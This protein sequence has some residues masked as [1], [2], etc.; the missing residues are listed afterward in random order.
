MTPGPVWRSREIRPPARRFYGEFLVNAQGEDVVAG[1]R[2]PFDIEEMANRLPVA[3]EELLE[4]QERLER[5]FRDM[6]DL[7]FTVER[8][9]LYLLQ[10]S[11]GKRTAA[12]AVR[13]AAEM[14]EEG[15][16]PEKRQSAASQP[17]SS[18]SSCTRS[19]I[20]RPARSRFAGTAGKPRG[21]ERPGGVRPRRGRAAQCERRGGD[22]RSRRDHAGRLPR[23]RCSTCGAHRTR[24]YDE[25][26]RGRG[27]RHGQVCDRRL[28]GDH[29]DPEKHTFS[30]DGT[31]VSEGDWITLDGA[32]GRV[33]I[34]DLP[35]IP[36]EIVRVMSGALPASRAP[37][38][39]RSRRPRL[40][41]R[42]ASSSRASERRHS[43]R[44]PRRAPASAP[45]ASGC[46]APSTCSSRANV[47]PRC[48]R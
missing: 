19:S 12:A 28:Q 27:S 9:K 39:S 36:S 5:H 23:H 46:A 11:T 4:T 35:T 26:R 20:H 7:E 8:G 14:V 45:R 13:I 48:A 37:C 21:R 42:G 22:S 31:T 32:T 41:G 34:G 24:R 30:V 33:F 29:V 40:G 10:T 47:S 1:I 17:T 16:S 18:I 44:C 6:Q 25:P 3:Y 43:E 15:S 2:T 38:I